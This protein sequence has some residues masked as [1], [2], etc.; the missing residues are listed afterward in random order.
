PISVPTRPAI[1]DS[2]SVAFSAVQFTGHQSGLQ[3]IFRLDGTVLTRIDPLSG[4]G[5]FFSDSV[6]LANNGVATYD[7]PAP[8]YAN[9]SVGDGQTT[10]IISSGIVPFSVRANDAGSVV[11]TG[12]QTSGDKTILIDGSTTTVIASASA[13]GGDAFG[14]LAGADI[15]SQGTVVFI[16]Q[17]NPGGGGAT[18]YRYQNALVTPLLN[19][20]ATNYSG[21]DGLPGIND[22]GQI[23]FF[24]RL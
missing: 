9:V 3:G 13:Y 24:A 19:L 8:A 4:N 10:K 1:N 5:Y 20:S 16:G 2:G 15:N 18:L 6:Y 14:Y 17:P 7:S 23:L 21:L 22:F 12:H 11:F